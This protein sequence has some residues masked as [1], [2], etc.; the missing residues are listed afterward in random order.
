MNKK[1]KAEEKKMALVKIA[2]WQDNVEFL[3]NKKIANKPKS[4]WLLRRLNSTHI[5]EICESKFLSLYTS[6]QCLRI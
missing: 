1:M 4:V 5:L 3:Q 2:D 6:F